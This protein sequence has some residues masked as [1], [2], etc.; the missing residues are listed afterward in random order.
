MVT[1]LNRIAMALGLALT[2]ATLR[3]A[4][5]ADVKAEQTQ[6]LPMLRVVV[7]RQAIARYGINADEVLD[8]VETV[9]GR[10]LGVIFRELCWRAAA[11]GEHRWDAGNTEAHPGRPTR[12]RTR[13]GRAPPKRSPAA[14]NVASVESMHRRTAIRTPQGPGHPSSIPSEGRSSCRSAR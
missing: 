5:A 1:W 7:D 13:A 10:P 11:G 4:G 8:V 2:L 14:M 9:G 12:Q 6:G 3:P